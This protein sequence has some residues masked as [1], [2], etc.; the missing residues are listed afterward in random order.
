[1]P[2]PADLAFIVVGDRTTL[3]PQLKALGLPLEIRPTEAPPAPT[4]R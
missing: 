3:E 2:T 1:M 4:P